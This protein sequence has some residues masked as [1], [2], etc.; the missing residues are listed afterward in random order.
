MGQE[1]KRRSRSM[2]RMM[3]YN[4]PQG[5][6]EKFNTQKSQMARNCLYLRFPSPCGCLW[7]HI[8]RYESRIS[9]N[10]EKYARVP[11]PLPETTKATFIFITCVLCFSITISLN[12]CSK[13][14]SEMNFRLYGI[15]HENYIIVMSVSIMQFIDE[16]RLSFS[17]KKKKKK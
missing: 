5:K 13:G 4:A 6:P 10:Q 16:K 2:R 7:R 14:R 15:L 9:A 17:V 3:D 11:K 8:M 1:A 12:N